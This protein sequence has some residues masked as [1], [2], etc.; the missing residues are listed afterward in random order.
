MSDQEAEAQ[1]R[2]Q[3][4]EWLKETAELRAFQRP[5]HEAAPPEVHEALLQARSR[6]D[7][8]EEICGNLSAVKAGA[9]AK[10]RVLQEQAQDAWD[11]LADSHSRQAGVREWEGKEERYARWR[12]ATFDQV[13]SARQAQLFADF[14]TQ[15]DTQAHRAF[16]GLS[17]VREELLASLRYLPWLSSLE[18]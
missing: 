11:K 3:V 16:R 7:R 17:A 5:G 12:L 2:A 14:A 18:Q 10:T 1:I 6:L 9:L 15:A 8:M 13:R 4:A